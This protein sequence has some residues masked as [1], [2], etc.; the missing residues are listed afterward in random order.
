MDSEDPMDA[1]ET[2]GACL[3]MKILSSVV[4]GAP[5]TFEIMLRGPKEELETLKIPPTLYMY[6][7]NGMLS[8]YHVF[9]APWKD[10][11]I[12]HQVRVP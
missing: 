8:M 2:L 1:V 9:Y 4:A 11:D 3:G 12:L 7:L 10:K 6:S 5:S